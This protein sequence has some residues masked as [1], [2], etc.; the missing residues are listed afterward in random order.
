MDL[1]ELA[2]LLVS[3]FAEFG[4]ATVW[5]GDTLISVMAF[6]GTQDEDLALEW[7]LEVDDFELLTVIP[8]L[9]GRDFLLCKRLHTKQS[10]LDAVIEL[11]E[12]IEKRFV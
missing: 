9:D 8:M 1:E 7:A 2:Q 12:A 11:Q 3:R 5:V 10:L 4:T 6:N